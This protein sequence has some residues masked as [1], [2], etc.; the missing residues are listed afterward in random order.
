MM[1]GDAEERAE[2]S[3]AAPENSGRNPRRYGVG[4]SN[5]TATMEHSYPETNQL[6]D[7]VVERENLGQPGTRVAAKT[8]ATTS[9]HNMNRRGTEPYARW[10]GRTAGATPPPTRLRPAGR[11]YLEVQVLSPTLS[12]QAFPGLFRVT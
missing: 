10:C 5:I 1:G 3:A 6:M 4:A 8:A 9:T 7:A 2:R 11:T 12:H